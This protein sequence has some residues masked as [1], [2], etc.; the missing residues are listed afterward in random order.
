M[1]TAVLVVLIAGLSGVAVAGPQAYSPA[2]A[3]F[4]TDNGDNPSNTV[5]VSITGTG[6]G[7]AQAGTFAAADCGTAAGGAFAIVYSGFVAIFTANS[8]DSNQV[9]AWT[10]RQIVLK[11]NAANGNASA[12]SVRVCT[13]AGKSTTAAITKWVYEHVDVPPSSGTNALPLSMTRDAGG[14]V[15]VNEEFHRQMKRLTNVQWTLFS[16][17]QLTPPGIFALLFNGVDIRTPTSELGEDIIVDSLNRVWLSEGG[18]TPYQGTNPNHGRIVMYDPGA[19]VIRTLNVP[20]DNNGIFGLSWDA[21]RG[22]IWFTES[23]RSRR[24]APNPEVVAYRARLTSF[25]PICV[26]NYTC[27]NPPNYAIPNW[28]GNFDFD[29][30]AATYTCAGGSTSP[31]VVGTCQNGN[32]NINRKCF[33]NQDCVLANLRCPAG[34]YDYWCFHEYEI[35]DT[36]GVVT[37]PS[38]VLAHSDGTVWYSAYWGGNHVGRLDPATGTFQQYPLADP[39]D[40]AS[41]DYGSCYCFFPNGQEAC[42]QR[43]CLYVLLGQGPWSLVE[44]SSRNV[45][46][47]F[48]NQAA[49]GR[50]DFSRANDPACSTL[51]GSG[52]NPCVTY[53]F[54]PNLDP[55]TQYPHSAQVDAAGNVWLTEVTSADTD[56]TALTSVGYRQ[57][58]T[59][60]VLM[61]PPLSFYPK[62]SGTTCTAFGGAGMAYDPVTGGMWFT[63]FFRKRLG[64]VRP[65]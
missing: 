20:G 48:Q 43:C 52:Q 25:D 39:A 29:G 22:K 3:L 24:E 33:T 46:M 27:P 64:R 36:A 12:L 57:V 42:P 58:S 62:M 21:A 51:D 23:R 30:N 41:C 37:I 50:F 55:D 56:C 53:D 10:D 34:G 7:A 35:P 38:H 6:F 26:G 4:H 28:V 65:Q 14:N 54:V 49:V 2:L 13:P 32:P 11:L 9:S 60:R 16:I 31:P 17:P 40:K 1:R 44:E 45:S 47:S 15:W 18:K 8:N 59:G 61:F 19:A 5:Q 63:D